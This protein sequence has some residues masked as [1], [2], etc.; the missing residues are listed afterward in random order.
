MWFTNFVFGT[1]GLLGFLRL[2]SEQGTTRGGGWE[3][4]A[5]LRF[6]GSRW[7]RAEGSA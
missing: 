4:P 1:L 5:W 7:R 3:L 2:G 6:G